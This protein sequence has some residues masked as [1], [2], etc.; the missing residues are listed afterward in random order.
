AAAA[1]LSLMAAPL[2]A[3]QPG[4]AP[5]ARPPSGGPGEI[6]GSLVDAENNA[7]ISAASV[8]VRNAAGDLIAGAIASQDGSFSIVGLQPGSYTLRYTMIGYAV[9]NSQPI[10]I[11]PAQP[12]VALGAIKLT[13]QAVEIS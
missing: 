12:R 5:G 3:Q 11:T 1:L 13:R 9:E 10:N 7:P 8:S 6:R 4:Q 2:A